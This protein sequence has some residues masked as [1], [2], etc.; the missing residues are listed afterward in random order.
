M[1][2]ED[3][4]QQQN[5]KIEYFSV[6][7]FSVLISSSVFAVYTSTVRRVEKCWVNFLPGI[8]KV[9]SGGLVG[10]SEVFKIPQLER[11]VYHQQD[12]QSTEFLAAT[13]RKSELFTS[14]RPST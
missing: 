13:T 3:H 1:I 8:S 14:E 12:T 6:F 7:C 2:T 5:N 4:D 10:T 9:A 11:Y